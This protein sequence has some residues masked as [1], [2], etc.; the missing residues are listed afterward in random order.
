MTAT[1]Q[2]TTVTE[3]RGQVSP[4]PRVHYAFNTSSR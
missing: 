2:Q 3:L 1:R 4:L